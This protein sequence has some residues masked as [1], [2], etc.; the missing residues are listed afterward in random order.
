MNVKETGSKRGFTLIEIMIATTIFLMITGIVTMAFISSQR[1]FT[2]GVALMDVSNDA[3]TAV[4]S[5]ESDLNWASLVE[6]SHGFVSGNYSTGDNQ[7]V[8]LLPSMDSAGD[9]IDGQYDYVAYY[10]DGTDPTLLDREVSPSGS[11]SRTSTVH[12]VARN[13]STLN[14][15]F[16]GTNLSSVANLGLVDNVTASITTAKT[17]LGGRNLQKTLTIT[18]KLRNY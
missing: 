1:S 3:L 7:L 15:S 9:I 2:T 6:P 12:V 17:V 18:A 8:L 5:L 14:F 4:N 11:S 10:L 13:V 16:D